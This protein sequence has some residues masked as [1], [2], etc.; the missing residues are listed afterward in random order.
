[1]M[2]GTKSK[3]ANDERVLSYSQKRKKQ[4]QKAK[5]KKHPRM[6]REVKMAS[7]F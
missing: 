3:N 6:S 2:R 5:S 7:A 1:M 4:K